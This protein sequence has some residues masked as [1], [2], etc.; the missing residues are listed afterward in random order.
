MKPL[1]AIDHLAQI[2]GSHGT[3]NFLE[4]SFQIV[5]RESVFGD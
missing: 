5:N 3:M 1:Y 4:G 2:T